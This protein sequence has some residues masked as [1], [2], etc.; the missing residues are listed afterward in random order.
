MDCLACVGSSPS[1]YP[2]GEIVPSSKMIRP[3]TGQRFGRTI[4][5]SCPRILVIDGPH[6]GVVDMGV[7]SLSPGVPVA[8]CFPFSAAVGI[9]GLGFRI[10]RVAILPSEIL[11]PLAVVSLLL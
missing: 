5:V 1:K 3:G 8:I 2:A 11:S 10:F 4:A 7:V 9:A 6:S